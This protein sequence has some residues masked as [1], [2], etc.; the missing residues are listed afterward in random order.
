MKNSFKTVAFILAFGLTSCG[1]AEYSSY[2]ED[3]HSIESTEE[4]SA[5]YSENFESEMAYEQGEYSKKDEGR[6]EDHQQSISSVAANSINDGHLRF[7]RTSQIKF[8]TESVRN[9]TYYLENAVVNLGGIVTYTNLYSEVENIKKI[10]VS[11][12]SSLKVT[13]YQMKNNMTI[14]IPKE[15]LDSLLK[16]ISKSVTFLDERIVSAEE[17][18]LTELKNQLE[19]NRL[20]NY[21]NQLMD[22]IED[23]SDKINKVVDAYEN[24]LQK[25]KLEDDALIRNLELDYNVDYSTIQLSFYQDTTMDKEMIEN[26]L[27]IEEFEPTFF[28]KLGD[29]FI[30]GWNA[31]LSFI[32][33]ITNLWFII[34]PA[35]IIGIILYRKRKTNKIQ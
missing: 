23:K 28:S 11:N 13:T 31:I 18:S 25:Q 7:I 21:Q 8:K 16:V 29:S 24:M 10:A 3:N 6:P 32:V 30:N 1:N 26:E 22:A 15:H 9:T 34:L 2:A 20:A 12:D 4:A 17:I 19:Q 27:N 33:V 5:A 35:T 14:R